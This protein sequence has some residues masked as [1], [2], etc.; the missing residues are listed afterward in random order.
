[1]RTNDDGQ[2]GSFSSKHESNGKLRRSPREQPSMSTPQ[3]LRKQRQQPHNMYRY[4][5]EH[6]SSDFTTN[7]RP[8]QYRTRSRRETIESNSAHS[9]GGGLHL[10]RRHDSHDAS[11]PQGFFNGSN[12]DP[13]KKGKL[14]SGWDSVSKKLNNRR[15]ANSNKHTKTSRKSAWLVALLGVLILVYIVFFLAAQSKYW[16]HR[17]TNALHEQIVDI[18][19]QIV[20]KGAKVTDQA[21]ERSGGDGVTVSLPVETAPSQADF[22]S[23]TPLNPSMPSTTS[24]S[25]GNYAFRH[26]SKQSYNPPPSQTSAGVRANDWFADRL[27]SARKHDLKRNRKR[28]QKTR[29]KNDTKESPLWYKLGYADDS[30]LLMNDQRWSGK[31]TNTGQTDQVYDSTFHLCGEHARGAAQTHPDNYYPLNT[32]GHH[33]VAPLGPSSRVFITGLLSPL[34]IHL[35]LALSKQCNVTSIYGTDSQFPNEPL[36]RLEMSERLQL[37]M[38]ELGG[39]VEISLPFLGLEIDSL[40]DSS[41][42]VDRKSLMQS[43]GED[44]RRLATGL[45]GRKLGQSLESNAPMKRPARAN[46]YALPSNPGLSPNGVGILNHLID[47]KPTHV[48][49]LAPTQSDAL[50]SSRASP[51]DHFMNREEEEEDVLQETISTRPHLYDLRMNNVGMEQLLS[52][53]SNRVLRKSER[54]KGAEVLPH[55]VYASSHDAMRFADSDKRMNTH[56][57]RKNPRKSEDADEDVG[58]AGRSDHRHHKRP[59]RDLHGM[60]HL[61][62]EIMASSYKSMYGISTVGLR[63][64]AIYGK[65]G[66]GTPSTSVPLFHSLR[67]RKRRGTSPAVDTVETAIRRV[68]RKW[69]DV[70]RAVKKEFEEDEDEDGEE[71]GEEEDENMRSGRRL[72]SMDGQP[73]TSLVE[74]T[75]WS[76]LAHDRRDFVYLDDAV[77]GIISAM[78]YRPAQDS[79]TVFNIGSG[80]SSTLASFADDIEDLTEGDDHS[81]ASDKRHRHHRHDKKVIDVEHSSAAQLAGITSGEYL[82]WTASTSIQDGAAKM[83]AWHLDRAMPYFPSA[84]VVGTSESDFSALETF[85][86]DGTA[87]PR[88][89]DSLGVLSRRGIPLCSSE[90][91]PT[92]SD[93]NILPCASECSTTACS[94]SPFDSIIHLSH[95]ATED[96]DVVMYT[97]S[98]G[99]DVDELRLETEFSDGT[100]QEGWLE[101]TVCTIA[102]I[103]SESKLV[104]SVIEQIPLASLRKRGLTKRSSFNEKVDKLNGYLAHKGW[105]LI[106]LPGA[107]D[108]LPS[109]VTYI[110][111]LSPA[112]LFHPTVR[113]IM[114][115]DEYFSHTPYPDDAQFLSYETSRGALKARKATVG[116]KKTKYTIPEE[117][118]RRAV[119]LVSPMRNVPKASGDKMPLKDVTRSLMNE[120]GLGDG[121]A[122]DNELRDVD[123]QRGFY[124]MSRGFINSF[125]TRTP[126]YASRHVIEIESFIRSRWVVH[127]LKLDEGHQLRCQWY[128][129]H[130]KWNTHLDQLSFA[131]VMA[132]RDL[133]RKIITRQPLSKEETM[134]DKI[135][136]LKTD[137]YE[138]HPIYTL[139]D[140]PQAVHRS[141]INPQAIPDNIAELPEQEISDAKHAAEENDTPSFYVRIMSD[142][143][144]MQSRKQ[145]IKARNKR[146][147]FI[148]QQRSKEE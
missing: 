84:N 8:D 116:P 131:Y 90:D 83:L 129:E 61:H 130:V 98:L 123:T 126:N 144:M 72:T 69:M 76:H 43:S 50:L 122:D 111:K 140:S 11:P 12:I 105:V 18:P 23:Q 145:W 73:P 37:L 7:G 113:K 21:N 13:R 5:I 120:V 95:D 92:C 20:T 6:G 75:G 41:S 49:H 29:P 146:R 4:E 9:P 96:C 53:L 104:E 14:H 1:M 108:S 38:N 134:L 63:F 71:G 141:E 114:F 39:A 87:V 34:G 132:K 81:Q 107:T 136:K 79:P 60:S 137:A 80:E 67:T 88:P 57:S 27:K 22:T 58:V 51:T 16:A 85:Y 142:A 28:K 125:G 121:E 148:E 93:E 65:R 99:Y 46:K 117:P 147:Q 35:S 115:V 32:N 128:R 66:F 33:D 82:G 3:E 59:P 10:R 70:V 68:Y 47:Y 77:E 54:K 119:L 101:S 112:R 103:P 64:D 109:D 127:H 100:E 110:P 36:A 31:P 48:V 40:A 52:T 94:P 86:E 24:S 133:V 55:F 138:W 44:M 74:E 2:E 30:T 26:P 56:R 17:G 25:G 78:Q 135:I 143:V 118:E 102:Y 45:L 15:T 139:E 19:R 106:L 89:I 91:D 124:E 62:A 97:M 42:A